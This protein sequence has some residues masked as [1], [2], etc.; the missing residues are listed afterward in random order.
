VVEHGGDG[1]VAER[2]VQRGALGLQGGRD[3]CGQ[4]VPPREQA[5]GERE[6]TVRDLS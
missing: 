2:Q 1:V 6:L 3:E 4:V 5:C